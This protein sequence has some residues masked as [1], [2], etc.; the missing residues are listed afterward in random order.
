MNTSL[1]NYS[2]VKAPHKHRVGVQMKGL[3]QRMCKL[4]GLPQ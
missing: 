1:I 3:L 4:V 2:M